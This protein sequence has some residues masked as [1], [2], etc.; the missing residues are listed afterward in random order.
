MKRPYADS[1]TSGRFGQRDDKPG[2]NQAPGSWRTAIHQNKRKPVRP[3]LDDWPVPCPATPNPPRNEPNHRMKTGHAF[4]RQSITNPS[5]PDPS[6]TTNHECFQEATDHPIPANNRKGL[7]RQAP[8][9][10]WK[11]NAPSPYAAQQLPADR[12]SAAR[13]LLQPSAHQLSMR[14]QSG[15]SLVPLLP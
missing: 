4:H 1:R 3:V 5:D 14:Y 13:R 6:R 12:D 8:L 11:E 7:L 15:R 9:Q 10:E 2:H